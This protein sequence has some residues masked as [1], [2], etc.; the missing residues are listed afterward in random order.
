M[1]NE[2]VFMNHKVCSGTGGLKDFFLDERYIHISPKPFT[3]PQPSFPV[4]PLFME[5]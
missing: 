1:R 4:P 5:V 2:A 3:S